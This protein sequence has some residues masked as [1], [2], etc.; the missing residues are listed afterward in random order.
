[1][2]SSRAR[3]PG[4]ATW[5][6][7]TRSSTPRSSST[8]EPPPPERTTTVDRGTLDDAN[9]GRVA[10]MPTALTPPAGTWSFEDEE[11]LLIGGS[12]A[13]TD[14]FVISATT[15]VPVTSKLY[16]GYLSGKLQVLKQGNLR[17]AVQAGVAGVFVK[18][19]SSD[20]TAT[21]TSS[22]STS[23]LE[24]GAVATYCLDSD[25][26]S[27]VS[28]AAVAGFAQQNNSSVPVGFMAGVVA[29]ISEH[30][31][32]VGEAD[33]A[34][35]FGNLSG[36]ANGILAWYGVRFTSRQIGVD[37]EL[38]RPFCGGDSCKMDAFPLGFPFVAFSYRGLD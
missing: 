26:Y 33:T 9:A 8:G 7:L 36:Q 12:Y 6:S 11:L 10:V 32:F 37:L 35:V 25:C 31:R 28:G 18:D 30:V 29:R 2:S 5:A 34:H 13:V 22:D 20:G 3:S 21:N 17:V 16:W 1:M 38:V 24:L 15:M 23:G 14:Q 4:A 19:T 27:H